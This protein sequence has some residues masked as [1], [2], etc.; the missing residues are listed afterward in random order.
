VTEILVDVS[1]GHP[2][3]LVW[4]ALTDRRL[5]SEWFM[6]TDLEPHEGRAFRLFPTD[7]PG[8]AGP[9][10]GELIEL[11]APRR[12]VMLWRGTNMHCRIVWEL[13]P[14][15]DGARLKMAQTGFLGV[16]GSLRRKELQRTYDELFTKRLP[17]VLDR[18]AA[19][20]DLLPSGSAPVQPA[21]REPTPQEPSLMTSLADPPSDED[22]ATARRRWPAW[23]PRVSH[24]RRGQ[25]LA[26]IGAAVLAVLTMALISS[27]GVRPLLPPVGADPDGW[28][29]DPAPS[30][31]T[32][33]GIPQPLP[34]GESPAAGGGPTT[35]AGPG[36]PRVSGT[37]VAP[38]PAGQPP[39]PPGGGPLPP[40][41]PPP[42]EPGPGRVVRAGYHTVKTPGS[43]YQ[44]EIK[45]EN[46]GT[47]RVD[48]WAVMVTIQDGAW[49]QDVSGASSSQDGTVITFTPKSGAGSLD[50]GESATFGFKIKSS[51]STGPV[52]CVIDGRSCAGV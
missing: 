37:P 3:E 35:T 4:R 29:L 47:L 32:T 39:P 34:A 23:L 10:E 2:P 21:P 25:L 11:A 17:G 49:I 20:G 13:E 38:P 44:G 8:L 5:L 9:I 46:I 48:H 33:S 15:T 40:P 42:P 31:P 1:L 27:L 30:G 12:M 51:G 16:K 43:G 45:V 24:Q 52:A 28:A 18:I 26:V 36:A 41:P 19:G 50:P 14:V 7:L 6:Q 22:E